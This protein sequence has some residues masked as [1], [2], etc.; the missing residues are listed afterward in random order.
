MDKLREALR[1]MIRDEVAR[2]VKAALTELPRTSTP[3][4]PEHAAGGILTVKAAAEYVGLEPKTPYNLKAAG[5]GPKAY[6][7]GRRTV[8]YPA[9]L[10]AWVKRRLVAE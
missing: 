3:G 6:K 8:Y 2:Q 7:H 9:D 4:L 5:E 10:T 1:E